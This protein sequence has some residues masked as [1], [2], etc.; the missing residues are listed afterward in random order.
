MFLPIGD[1]PNPRSIPWVNYLL[2][3]ANVVVWLFVALPLMS[4]R[5]DLQDPLLLEYLFELGVRGP[6]PAHS[7]LEQFKA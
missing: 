5:P 4:A 3:A 7:I 2:L 6:V 1:H